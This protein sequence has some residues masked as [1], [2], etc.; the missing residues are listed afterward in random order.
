MKPATPLTLHP[1]PRTRFV[2][3]WLASRPAEVGASLTLG[4]KWGYEYTAGW[5]VQVGD[6]EAHEVK[7][8]TLEQLEKQAAETAALLPGLSLYQIHSTTEE[9]GVLE[10][11]PVLAAIAALRDGALTAAPGAKWAPGLSVSSPQLP[12]IERAVA[13]QQGSAPL[14]ASVQATFN[15]FD[16]SAAGALRAAHEAG[17]VVIIKEA[18]ANGRVLES[19]LLRTEAQRLGTSVD[20]LAL[21]WVMSHDWVDICLSGAATVDHLRSNAEAL[22]LVPLPADVQTRLAE[23]LRQDPEEYWAER[24]CLA[25]T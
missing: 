24:K 16:Q 10:N 2:S 14:F 22:K 12:A 13:L 15:V 6:G 7:K 1:A 21:A 11:E 5:R 19:E 4:S 3:T 9:S 23:G 8:H 25:W 17:M 18:M 20:A